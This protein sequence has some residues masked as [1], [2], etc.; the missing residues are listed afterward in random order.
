MSN[1]WEETQPILLP[2][3][4]VE[5]KSNKPITQDQPCPL[6]QPY[7]VASVN[8]LPNCQQSLQQQNQTRTI[9][10]L[11]TMPK[12]CSTSTIMSQVDNQTPNVV[13]HNLLQS[14]SSE[15]SVP[16]N[17]KSARKLPNAS[18]GHRDNIEQR[19]STRST[20]NQLKEN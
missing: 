9:Y 19:S 14:I 10:H 17:D 2:Q 20:N 11:D 12:L 6:F 1:N 8:Y 15:A 4:Y 18:L 16:A 5:S 7:P 13:E 3:L